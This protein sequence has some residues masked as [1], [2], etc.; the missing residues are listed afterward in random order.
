MSGRPV[1]VLYNGVCP[2][3]RA[4]ACDLERRATAAGAG[5]SFTD[6]ATCPDA[7]GRAGVTLD[8]VR[9]KLHAILPDGR[10]LRGMPAVAVAWSVTPPYRLLGRIARL[11]VA[12]PVAAAVYHVVAHALWA[13][14]RAC[15]RW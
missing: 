8:E 5:V 11:P 3:C 12:A 13:W 15:G 10:V 6:V 4:G 7:L 1:E 2:I 14:N 9:L